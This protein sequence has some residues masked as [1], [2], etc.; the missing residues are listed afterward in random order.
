VAIRRALT[1]LGARQEVLPPLTASLQTSAGGLDRTWPAA[2]L[3]EV[4]N[5]LAD[6]GQAVLYF[7]TWAR[8]E[9]GVFWNGH[10]TLDQQ[11]D[12]SKPWSEVVEAARECALIEAFVISPRANLFATVEWIDR[13]EL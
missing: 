1:V 6:H 9:R 13:S 2:R 7:Q 4:I 11:L 3:A 10:E 8:T 5:E 12:F